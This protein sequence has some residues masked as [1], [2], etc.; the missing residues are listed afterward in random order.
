[1][2]L[3][4]VCWGRPGV[5]VRACQPHAWTWWYRAGSA[6]GSARGPGVPATRARVCPQTGDVNTW[7][8]VHR[9]QARAASTPRTRMTNYAL[10]ANTGH[11]TSGQGTACTQLFD[12][13]VWTLINENF[14]DFLFLAIW[15]K[16]RSQ[17]AVEILRVAI[18]ELFMPVTWYGCRSSMLAALL[19]VLVQYKRHALYD[20]S[21]SFVHFNCFL[22]LCFWRQAIIIIKE[23]EFLVFHNF[24]TCSK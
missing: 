8:M 14:F 4:A 2:R 9:E 23:A 17:Y 15:L 21:L 18:P 22:V 20:F 24:I 16:W 7:S 5:F 1:M 6:P 11:G 12:I 19:L 10:R 13:P 3:L